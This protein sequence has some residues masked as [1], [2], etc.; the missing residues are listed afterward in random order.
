MNK[1]GW[2][3]ILA[4]ACCC[5]AQAADC[6]NYTGARVALTKDATDAVGKAIAAIKAGSPRG[7]MA[8]SSNKLLLVRRSVSAGADGRSGNV[9]LPLHAADLDTH[10]NI[11][12]ANL[13]L[14]DFTER[15]RFDAVKTDE[16]IAVQ[17][18]VCEGENHCDD[19][20]PP[21]VDLPFIMH[22]LL[23]CNQGGQRVFAFNDGLFVTDMRM[24]SGGLPTGAALFF[25]KTAKAYRLAGLIVQH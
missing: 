13:T 7:L 18:D 21:S 6:E 19:G 14:A 9:R 24:E 12:I 25:T 8:I 23:Q 11:R 1:C 16:A 22:D 17:R 10:L 4:L 15:G 20:L 2:L 3:L 5:Q